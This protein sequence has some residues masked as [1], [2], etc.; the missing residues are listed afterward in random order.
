MLK[1]PEGPLLI[2]RTYCPTLLKDPRSMRGFYSLLRGKQHR[3]SNIKRRTSNN[4]KMR[5]AECGVRSA[6]SETA[7]YAKYAKG[8]SKPQISRVSRISRFYFPPA[9]S[10]SLRRSFPSEFMGILVPP[11][12]RG[13]MREGVRR[14]LSRSDPPS[15]GAMAR[16]AGA[17]VAEDA[18]GKT[19]RRDR[20]CIFSI[21]WIIEAG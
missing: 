7:K 19:P 11:W 10:A 3:T 15:L 8:E 12:F 4:C 9:L 14:I 16:Q 21:A 20:P 2:V 1:C 5:S 18:R 13:S 6:K 17:R